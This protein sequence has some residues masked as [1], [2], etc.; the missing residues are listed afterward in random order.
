MLIVIHPLEKIALILVIG[1][2]APPFAAS[3][4]APGRTRCIKRRDIV[5]LFGPSFI[6]VSLLHWFV[7]NCA[8]PWGYGREEHGPGCDGACCA[9]TPCPSCSLRLYLGE[10]VFPTLWSWSEMTTT[11][12]ILLCSATSQRPTRQVQVVEPRVDLP[13]VCLVEKYRKIRMAQHRLQVSFQWSAS[14]PE[15]KRGGYQR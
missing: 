13:W 5:P 8:E 15:K 1:F 2:L 10:H 14:G 3:L 4:G 9:I 7:V 11:R 6:H 12:L